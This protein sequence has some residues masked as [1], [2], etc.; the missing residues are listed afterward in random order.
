[1][2]ISMNC[3]FKHCPY[4]AMM[5]FFRTRGSGSSESI[6]LHYLAVTRQVHHLLMSFWSIFIKLCAIYLSLISLALQKGENPIFIMNMKYW[7]PTQGGRIIYYGWQW[8]H[9]SFWIGFHCKGKYHLGANNKCHQWFLR[10]ILRVTI[11]SGVGQESQLD[12]LS[13]ACQR[14]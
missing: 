11:R 5:L 3:F 1:M 2:H 8:N 10:R 9:A 7:L 14:T 6:R 12:L 13:F 4:R